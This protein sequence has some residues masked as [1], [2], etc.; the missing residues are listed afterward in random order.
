MGLRGS[1]CVSGDLNKCGTRH[2]RCRSPGPSWPQHHFCCP[3]LRRGSLRPRVTP[4]H[5]SPG[6]GA[7][8][9]G[10]ARVPCFEVPPPCHLRP[11]PC[12][13]TAFLGAHR[14]APQKALRRGSSLQPLHLRP[15]PRP[16]CV[17]EEG[18]V[19]LR[20]A[21]AVGGVALGLCFPSSSGVQCPGLSLI[22]K[23]IFTFQPSNLINDLY[24]SRELK[25]F[26]ESL[27]VLFPSIF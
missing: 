19:C 4:A 9:A 20:G 11:S 23:Y 13:R 16:A 17:C 22:V 26:E 8:R 18:R 2:Y 14:R 25:S 24:K 15:L 21:A 7:A 6:P 27:P 3:P 5:L 10:S 1:E 12:S